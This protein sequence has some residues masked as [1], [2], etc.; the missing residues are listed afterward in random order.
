MGGDADEAKNDD[1]RQGNAFLSLQASDP[2]S[3]GFL[4][5]CCPE[6]VGVD[7]EVNVR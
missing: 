5:L 1:P 4:M 6:I 3:E 2:P 7:E